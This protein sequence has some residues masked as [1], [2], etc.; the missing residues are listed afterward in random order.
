M[1]PFTKFY[2]VVNTFHTF[3]GVHPMMRHL[4]IVMIASVLSSLSLAAEVPPANYDEEKV[5][6]YTLPDPLIANDGSKIDTAAK[7]TSG[8]RAEILEL[9]EKHVYG[10]TVL[11]RP[12][13]LRFENLAEG[14]A[15][16]GKAIRKIV[17]I[18]TEKGGESPYFDVLFYIPKLPRNA[19]AESTAKFPVALCLNFMGNHAISD[20]PGI[21]LTPV[22]DRKEGTTKPNANQEKNRGLQKRRWPVDLLLSRGYAL[23]TVYYGQIEPDFNGGIQY[24]VR[25]NLPRPGNDE[26]GAIGAWAW[27][28]SRVMDYI[29]DDGAGGRL[30]PKKVM[31]LGHSRLGKTALWAGA[32]DQR[33]AVIVSNNSGCGGAALSRREYGETVHRITTRFPHWFAASFKQYGERIAECPVDQHELI[34]LIAPR[35][36]YVASATKDRWADPKGEFL[37][38]LHANP[39]YRL[40]GTD[41]FGDVTVMPEPD[42]SVGGSVIRYHIRTGVHDILEFDWTQYLDLADKHFR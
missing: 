5:P 16:E 36:V 18:H 20:D 17:R 2:L 12:V 28:L 34:A 14:E 38:A 25:R 10:K 4:M 9:F 23:A 29:A 3:S 30:D 8:R 11:G 21:P 37:S 15:F 22:W 40:L 32:Q 42:R 26:W 35:P 1:E 13:D 39:V 19:A 7:W 41:G 24:G 27:G 6:V 33:F 31:V